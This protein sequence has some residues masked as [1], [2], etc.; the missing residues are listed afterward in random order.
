MEQIERGVIVFD[1]S[2]RSLR[3]LGPLVTKHPETAAF[4]TQWVES[5]NEILLWV[6]A[7]HPEQCRVIALRTADDLVGGALEEFAD[8]I[9]EAVDRTRIATGPLPAD[10]AKAVRE[11][12]RKIGGLTADSK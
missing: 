4:V 6:L 2:E 11:R 10:L 9:G 8:E 3:G 7:V 12:W 5:E 1:K